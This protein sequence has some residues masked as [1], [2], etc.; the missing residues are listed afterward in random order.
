MVSFYLGQV[1]G[2]EILWTLMDYIMP[3][4]PTNTYG[5]FKTVGPISLSC[6]GS[7]IVLGL[8]YTQLSEYDSTRYHIDN[9]E[10]RVWP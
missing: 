3:M 4:G 2:D 7:S 8:S 10:W 9:I 5:A 1:Q 6:A